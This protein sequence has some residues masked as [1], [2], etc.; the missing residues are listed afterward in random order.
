MSARC[1][2]SRAGIWST[3]YVHRCL[4]RRSCSSSR[5]PLPFRLRAWSVATCRPRSANQPPIDLG[6]EEID[7]DWWMEYRAHASGLEA[8]F[9]PAIIGFAAP[10]DNLSALARCRAPR[11]R[12]LS[13]QC[14]LYARDLGVS[15]G[16]ADSIVSGRATDRFGTF[17]TPASPHFPQM[18]V[19]SLVAA[20]VAVVLYVTVHAL[21]FGQC[22]PPF[23]ARRPTSG[24][25]FSCGWFST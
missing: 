16:G 22:S 13:A 9:T 21:L 15:G 2:R 17:I 10:L 18:F 14:C 4:I 24:T 5:S 7:A 25:R 19:V 3:L 20:V 1:V 12:R 11:P 23:R 6:A 8:T